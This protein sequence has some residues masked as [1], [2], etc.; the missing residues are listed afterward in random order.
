MKVFLTGGTG[1]LGQY[2]LAE[3]LRRGHEVF[4]LYRSE[5]KRLAAEAF[6]EGTGLGQSLA[7]L[8]MLKGDLQDLGAKWPSW[9]ERVAGFGDMEAILHGAASLK[10]NSD[11]T[12]EPFRTNRE[13]TRIVAD[14]ASSRSLSLHYI[15]TAFVCG[16][17]EKDTIFE[18][19]HPQAEFVND[20]ETSKWQAEQLLLDRATILRPSIILGDTI[21]GR[22]TS[23][24][25]W[26]VILKTLNLMSRLLAAAPAAVRRRFTIKVPADAQGVTNL[27]PVDYVAGAVVRIFEDKALH[28]RIYH[29]THPKP[30]TNE[31]LNQVI[32]RRLG[33]KGIRFVGSRAPL[34]EPANEIQ[35]VMRRQ[36]R[37]LLPYFS[38]NYVFDRKNTDAALKDFPAPAISEEYLNLVMD[39][40]LESDWGR[41][42]S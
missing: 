12:G 8:K 20:Y 5:E 19:A 21:S 4:S 35:R 6:L 11:R 33:I 28:N 27:V 16:K 34:P 1:F 30:P 25:G 7:H 3:L 37:T 18:T 17:T 42:E 2:L 26:Y 10:M 15:S 22:T 9:A 14:L 31:W 13:G 41:R 29:L 39:Y 32:C 36:V 40:A 23:F 38:R 24:Y